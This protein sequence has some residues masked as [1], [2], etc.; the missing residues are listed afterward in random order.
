MENEELTTHEPL[1][2]KR[3]KQTIEANEPYREVDGENYHESCAKEMFRD[4]KGVKKE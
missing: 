1:T 3:C 2:C 4:W